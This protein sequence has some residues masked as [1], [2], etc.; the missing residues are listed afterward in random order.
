MPKA[1]WNIHKQVLHHRG[2]TQTA[3]IR[4]RSNQHAH[5]QQHQ[6]TAAANTNPQYTSMDGKKW[7]RVRPA[8]SLT[9]H[10]GFLTETHT[11]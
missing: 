6:G 9:V 10:G 1:H 4:A 7:Q 2:K 11:T 8:G 5:T 3:G